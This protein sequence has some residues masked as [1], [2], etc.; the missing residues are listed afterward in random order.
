MIPRSLR[1]SQLLDSCATDHLPPTG[2]RYYLHR[3][4]TSSCYPPSPPHPLLSYGTDRII[5]PPPPPNP[6]CLPAPPALI[7]YHSNTQHRK[8]EWAGRYGGKKG[9]PARL[10]RGERGRRCAELA[11]ARERERE[12]WNYSGLS[13]LCIVCE[14][15]QD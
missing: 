2:Q 5:Q 15:V 4:D 13:L 10:V 7:S 12:Y 8:Y 9:G 1:V 3:V 11:R 6:Q 14:C